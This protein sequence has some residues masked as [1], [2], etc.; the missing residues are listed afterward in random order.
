M[1]SELESLYLVLS[2]NLR[3]FVAFTKTRTGMGNWMAQN[4]SCFSYYHQNETTRV[5][6]VANIH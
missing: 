6:N 2:C 5:T 4:Q 3:P 1:S